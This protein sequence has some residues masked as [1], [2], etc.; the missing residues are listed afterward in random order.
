VY[1]QLRIVVKHIF[2]AE[3]YAEFAAFASVRHGDNIDFEY[4][5]ILLGRKRP[6][7]RF[8]CPPATRHGILQRRRAFSPFNLVGGY[9]AASGPA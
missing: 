4:L 3:L 2:R 9:S 6:S 7:S 5:Q 8:Q 1:V